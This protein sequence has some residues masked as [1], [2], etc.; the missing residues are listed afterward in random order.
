VSAASLEHALAALGVACRVEPRDRLAVLVPA[1]AAAID[2]ALAP[3]ARATIVGLT[4]AHGFTHI[5][6]ELPGDS[7]GDA[8]RAGGA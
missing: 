4:R 6:L 1:H 7:D 2:A 3:D 8:S 5:A